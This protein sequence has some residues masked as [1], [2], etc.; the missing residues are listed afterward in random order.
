MIKFKDFV[1]KEVTKAGFFS[2]ARLEELNDSLKRA[3]I[4][5]ENQNINVLNIETV[6]LPNIHRSSEEGSTDTD[7]TTSGDMSSNWHQFIRVWYK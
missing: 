7:I 1:P 3:N 4:W 5:I 6:V 2:S